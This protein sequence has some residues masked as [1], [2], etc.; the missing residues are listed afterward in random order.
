MREH[1]G[2]RSDVA[3]LDVVNPADRLVLHDPVAER[4]LSTWLRLRERHAVEI[5]GWPLVHVESTSRR[6]EL[7]CDSPDLGVFVSLLRHV[8]GDPSAMLTVVGRDLAAHRAVDLPASARISRDDETLMT[9][10]LAPGPAPAPLPG[11]VAVRDVDGPRI[12][13]RLEDGARIAAEATMAIQ[14]GWVVFDRVETSPGFRRRGL[15]RHLMSTMCAEAFAVGARHGILAASA[16]GCALYASLGWTVE[17][18]LLSIVGSG[19]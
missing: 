19:P 12:V 9:T 3:G 8:A 10:T 4:W 15:G 11:L 5:D 1:A 18:Q 17:R 13:H 2:Q 7:L 16:D 6:T 14:E